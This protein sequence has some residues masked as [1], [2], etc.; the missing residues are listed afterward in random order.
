MRAFDC[1]LGNAILTSNTSF[2]STG[3]AKYSNCSKWTCYTK[4]KPKNLS[5]PEAAF[6]EPL[7]CVMHSINSTGLFRRDTAVI[8]GATGLVGQSL[9]DQLSNADHIEN[10]ITLT[11]RPIN[12]SSKIPTRMG[13]FVS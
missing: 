11:R 10:I 3:C 4:K 13:C 1:L 9:V 6:L 7:S 12:Y 5:F 8:I 2:N